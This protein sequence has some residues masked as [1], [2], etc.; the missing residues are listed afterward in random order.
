MLN[1]LVILLGCSVHSL[2]VDRVSTALE[3]A[4][5]NQS[6]HITWFLSGGVKNNNNIKQLTEAELMANYLI[7]AEPYGSQWSFIYDYDATNTAEN[8]NNAKTLYDL[9]D[10]I[11]IVTSNF[12]YNR[13]SLIMKKIF[14]NIEINNID[15]ILAEE[16]LPDSH[17]WENIHI[18]NID[19]DI[20]KLKINIKY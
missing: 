13:A 14:N 7:K 18:Q 6:E 3:F 10:K 11:Y 19:N 4:Q 17:F 16:E 1:I 5:L 2:L 15:W 12:H 8:F 9:Y 20:K